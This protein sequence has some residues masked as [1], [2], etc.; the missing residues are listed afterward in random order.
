MAGRPEKFETELL[1]EVRPGKEL[2]V[3]VAPATTSG[4][5][6]ATLLIRTDYPPENP[7]T[8]H[9]YVRVK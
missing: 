3:K 8:H 1:R 5:E 4:P 6:S 2:E 9:A 7:A